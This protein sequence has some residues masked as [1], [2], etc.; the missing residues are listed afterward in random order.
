MYLEYIY[1]I[2]KAH[3]TAGLFQHFLVNGADPN[4]TYKQL[5]ALLSPEVKRC[6]EA[7]R[8]FAACVNTS[9]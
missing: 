1:H 2:D 7:R 3:N 4:V 9:A 6:R 5:D 8:A